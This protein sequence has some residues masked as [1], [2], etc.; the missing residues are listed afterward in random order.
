MSLPRPLLRRLRLP[1]RHFPTPRSFARFERS[2]RYASD[3]AAPPERP[4]RCFRDALHSAVL[5]DRTEQDARQRFQRR[6][7]GANARHVLWEGS[8]LDAL[9]PACVKQ[10]AGEHVLL[11][12]ES[13]SPYFT[14][15]QHTA[16]LRV[17]AVGSEWGAAALEQKLPQRLVEKLATA[18]KI[19]RVRFD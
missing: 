11:V 19:V 6:D 17:P 3:V 12:A 5:S 15:E 7:G 13:L 14:Q 1:F 16:I 4:A 10:N 18:G 9:W 2:N 8:V